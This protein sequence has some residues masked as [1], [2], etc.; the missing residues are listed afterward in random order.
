MNVLCRFSDMT[1]VP[2][3]K[4][5]WA[6]KMEKKAEHKAAKALEQKLKAEKK[7][8]QEVMSSSRVANKPCQGSPFFMTLE[9]ALT[10]VLAF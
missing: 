7:A 4:T 10:P 6:V 8:K 9:G 2:S 5:S 1:R 3:Q